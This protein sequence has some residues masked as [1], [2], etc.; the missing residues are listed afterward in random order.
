MP[1]KRACCIGGER[2]NF[3]KS[4][5]YAYKSSPQ[6]SIGSR[7]AAEAITT[8]RVLRIPRQEPHLS[9]QDDEWDVSEWLELLQL[10]QQE[11]PSQHEIDYPP[12]EDLAEIWEAIDFDNPDPPEPDFEHAFAPDP[13]EPS[14]PIDLRAPDDV[15]EV[16]C[17]GGHW[18]MPYDSS[19]VVWEFRSPLA[20]DDMVR[21]L[22]A[23]MPVHRDKWLGAGALLLLAAACT[24]A[25]MAVVTGI[26]AP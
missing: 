8:Y 9:W 25:V 10:E 14:P 19:A 11:I 3:F 24:E 4:R 22:N 20:A 12:P 26:T 5:R 15:Y 17:L 18:I 16:L 23:R 21:R 2:H 1:K 7:G 6:V 13:P